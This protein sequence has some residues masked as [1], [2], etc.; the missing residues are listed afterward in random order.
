LKLRDDVLD[1]LAYEPIVDPAHIG[2]AV[3]Q[4]IVTLT[5]RPLA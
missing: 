1:E 4:D 3:D 2:V 5:G